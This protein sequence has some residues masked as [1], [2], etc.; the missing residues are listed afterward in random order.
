[1][2]LTDQGVISGEAIEAMV[3]FAEAQIKSSE[4]K[5]PGKN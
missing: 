2:T 3:D 4:R 1:L 5:P